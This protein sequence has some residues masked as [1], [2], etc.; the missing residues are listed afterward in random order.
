VR[1]K[2][3]SIGVI[4]HKLA[5][6]TG[7]SYTWVMK[8][9]PHRF[10]DSVQSERRTGSVTQRV[11]RILDELLRP[12]KMKGAL[13]LMN[14]TN[15]D[16]VSLIIKKNFYEEFEKKSLELGVSTEFSVLKALEDYHEKMEKAGVIQKQEY[17]EGRELKSHNPRNSAIDEDK[18]QNQLYKQ[19]AH[20]YLCIQRCYVKNH[21]ARSAKTL[22]GK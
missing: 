4:A 3:D 1:A 5:D 2:I 22:Y 19:L 13:K 16:F 10:K 6:E 9:L 7:M 21:S 12:P 18:G 15:T 11:T 14:Y 8:Y 17:A 20:T